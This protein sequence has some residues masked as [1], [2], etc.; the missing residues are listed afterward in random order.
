MEGARGQYGGRIQRRGCEDDVMLSRRQL[1][2][3]GAEGGE[4]K[5]E[6]SPTCVMNKSLLRIPCCLAQRG[7]VLLS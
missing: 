3:G 6:S 1:G 2:K 7:P 5:H 4:R